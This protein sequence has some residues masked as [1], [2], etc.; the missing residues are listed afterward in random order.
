MVDFYLT[1]FRFA[2]YFVCIL[3]YMMKL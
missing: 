3:V 2:L 1:N